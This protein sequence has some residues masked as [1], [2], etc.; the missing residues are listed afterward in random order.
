MRLP[1]RRIWATV[2]GLA[3]AAATALAS[4]AAAASGDRTPPTTPTN[5]RLHSAG[6]TWLYLAWDASTDNSGTVMYDVALGTLQERAFEP[7]QGFGGLV[8]GATYTGTVRAVDLAGNSSPPVSITVSTP[9]RTLPPPPVP[10]NLRG[11]FAGGALTAIA[12]DASSHPAGVSYLLRSG[13]NLLHSGSATSVTVFELLNI[14]CSVAPGG[15][16]AVTVEAL[17]GD[18]DFSGRSA[19][20]TVTIP[21]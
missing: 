20:L 15:T 8:P 17:S 9:A 5:L 3:L 11:V 7:L 12:W 6:H 14:D 16:Y 19:P 13:D 1:H 2:L 10:T 21:G 18:N 4:P